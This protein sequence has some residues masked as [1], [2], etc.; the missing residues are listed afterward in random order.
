MFGPNFRAERS[1]HLQ[2][3]LPSRSQRSLRG[4]I[5]RTRNDQDDPIPDA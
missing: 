1:M 2:R 3:V 5:H 4:P